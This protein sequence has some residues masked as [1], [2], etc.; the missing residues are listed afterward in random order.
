MSATEIVHAAVAVLLRNDGLVLLGRRPEGK[1]WAGWW[2]FPGGKIEEGESP[3][4]A[5]QR[6]LHEELGTQALEAYPWLT[7]TF[8]YPERTVKLHF[9]I[10]RRWTDEPHGKEDQQLSWQRPSDLTVGPMLPANTPILT[11]LALAPVYAI[12]NLAETGEQVF[13]SRLE[14]S[15]KDGLKLI[16]VREKQLPSSQLRQFAERVIEIAKP[17][18]AKVMLNSDMRLA[19]EL[20]ADGVHLSASQLIALQTRPDDLLC[21]AS[22]H[23]PAELAQ[24]EQLALDF[25]VLSPVL[26][27]RSHPDAQP[28]GWQGFTDLIQGY[29]LPVYA[30]GGLQQQDLQQAWQSGAHGI[31]M[32]RAAW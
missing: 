11:A 12:T 27:T 25:V 30:L 5:L 9:F 23:N 19:R 15:L 32:Q 22:C 29:A 4:P 16:Q 10:V 6:E 7:R 31:A 18:G 2:E 24:A 14:Q 28:L 13:F 8:A 17:Y 3:Y 1:P 21:A 26:P 20:G